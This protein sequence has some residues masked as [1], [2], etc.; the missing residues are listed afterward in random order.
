MTNYSPSLPFNWNVP[1]APNQPAGF[2]RVK[3]Q[4]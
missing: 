1:S 3:L 4:P 2:F